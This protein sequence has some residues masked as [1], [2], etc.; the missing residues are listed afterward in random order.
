MVSDTATAKTAYF[1]L[2][3]AH[4]R[5]GPPVWRLCS[6]SNLQRIFV[7]KKKALRAL[8]RL[9]SRQSC[10][11]SFVKLYILAIVCWRLLFLFPKAICQEGV[12]RTVHHHNTR[13]TA[14]FKLPVH[15]MAALSEEKPS[16]LGIKL[17]NHSQED[18]KK[19]NTRNFKKEVKSW[20][21]VNP[22]YLM[23]DYLRRR[24]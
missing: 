14:D 8:A 17:W 4:L 1:A 6:A 10:C 21:H 11:P 9:H 12:H 2:F 3:E 20:L 19:A 22:F 13:H 15:Q 5:F 24:N 16:Y 18:L 23:E 7:I